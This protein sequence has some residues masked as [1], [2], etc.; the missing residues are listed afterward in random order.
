MAAQTWIAGATPAMTEKERTSV[1]NPRSDCH[2]MDSRLQRLMPLILI[3]VAVVA[4]QSNR[5]VPPP[6]VAGAGVT[7]EYVASLPPEQSGPAVNGLANE[8]IAVHS[9]Q[10]DSQ[11]DLDWEACMNAR[12][13]ASFDRY[14]FLAQHCGDQPDDKAFRDC[15]LFGRAAVDWLLAAGA[16]PDTDFDWSKPEQSRDRAL[17]ELNRVLTDTCAGKPEEPGNSCM[18][19]ESARLL[20]LSDTVAAQCSARKELA[21]RGTC[22]VDAHDAAMYQA[23]LVSLEQ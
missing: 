23:A 9:S 20:N 16:N 18:T 7:P 4:C 8:L 21:E 3:C 13:L 14:G 19:T 6:E 17:K 10:C 15:V 2:P 1:E 11:L 22:I 5:S 12:M